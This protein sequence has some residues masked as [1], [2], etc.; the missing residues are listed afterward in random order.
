MAELALHKQEL[1]VRRLQCCT[2]TVAVA[3]TFDC[4]LLLVQLWFL[5]LFQMF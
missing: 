5:L 1:E 2:V 4:F 3:R